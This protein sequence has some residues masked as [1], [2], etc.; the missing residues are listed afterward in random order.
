MDLEQIVRPFQSKT[1]LSRNTISVTPP[2]TSENCIVTVG[3]E[4]GS[5]KTLNGSYR[6]TKT[7]Y[8][9]NK[10]KTKPKKVVTQRIKNPDDEEQYVDVDVIDRM[11]VST[12][13]GQDYQKTTHTTDYSELNPSA[14]IVDVRTYE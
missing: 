2:E 6:V 8:C 14:E 1:V 3:V 11:N 4:G 12:G 10:A 5:A 7:L 13:G 9:D